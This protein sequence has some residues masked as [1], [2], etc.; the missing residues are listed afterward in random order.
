MQAPPMQDTMDWASVLP[1]STPAMDPDVACTETLASCLHCLHSLLTCP[2]MHTP[3]HIPLLGRLLATFS[4]VEGAQQDAELPPLELN[5]APS[6]WHA[7]LQAPQLTELVA[8][9]QRCFDWVARHTRGASGVLDHDLQVSA[10]AAGLH[11]A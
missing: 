9:V 3:P 7:T 2:G 8:R 5:L 11:P 4:T 1:A 6:A 10:L